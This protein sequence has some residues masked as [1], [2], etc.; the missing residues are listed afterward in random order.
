V[1]GFSKR[2][3]I[4]SAFLGGLSVLPILANVR[5]W[6][7]ALAFVRYWSNNGHWPALALNG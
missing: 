1:T 7:T 3:L 5:Y 2:N 4:S 6:H